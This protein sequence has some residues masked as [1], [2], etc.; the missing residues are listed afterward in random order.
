VIRWNVILAFAAERQGGWTDVRTSIVLVALSVVTCAHSPGRPEPAPKCRDKIAA[1]DAG[2][3][4]ASQSERSDRVKLRL[5][6]TRL[7]RCELS[8]PVL[9]TDGRYGRSPA[10][11]RALR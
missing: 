3:H 1:L 8:N 5:D 7:R 9:H 2:H 10:P 11:S 4:F 6:E